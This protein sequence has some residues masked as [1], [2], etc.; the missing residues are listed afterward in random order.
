[1]DI[2]NLKVSLHKNLEQGSSSSESVDCSKNAKSEKYAYEVFSAAANEKKRLQPEF[3]RYGKFKLQSKLDEVQSQLKA[4]IIRYQL[5]QQQADKAESAQLFPNY[6]KLALEPKAQ[7]TVHSALEERVY[8][9]RNIF[10]PLCIGY[11]FDNVIFA[12]MV[13]PF[14][15]EY[16]LA[17]V[18]ESDEIVRAAAY[19]TN[20]NNSEKI[21]K[22]NEGDLLSIMELIK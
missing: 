17:T 15:I 12:N 6:S 1:M 5:E 22:I 11:N 4:Q 18:P 21:S 3:E 14:F 13:N 2:Y 16:D 9:S 20:A 10:N 19:V 7:R 8:I